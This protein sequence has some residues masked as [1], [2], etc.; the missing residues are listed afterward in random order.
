MLELRTGEPGWYD[1]AI[2]IVLL[3]LI[4]ALVFNRIQLE[5]SVLMLFLAAIM[6]LADRWIRRKRGTFTALLVSRDFALTLCDSKGYE[7]P[8]EIAGGCWVTPALIVIPTR[9]QGGGKMHMV[10]SAERNDPD[11]FRRF[12]IICRFGFAVPNSERHNVTQL[13]PQGII[14]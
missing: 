6:V 2:G 3:L 4:S 9:V 10:I 12:S 1:P 13:N 8:S 14:K 11:T 5:Y 7:F